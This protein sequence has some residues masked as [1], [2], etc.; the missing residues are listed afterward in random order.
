MSL[1]A[2]PWSQRPDDLPLTAEEV[3]AALFEAEGDVTAA[4]QRLKVGSLTLR[5]FIERSSRARAVIREMDSRLADKARSKL[6]QAL[7]DP[8]NRRVDWAIRYIL[9]SNNARHLGYSSTDNA[10]DPQRAAI[11]G[12]LVTLNLPPVEWQD[13]TKIGPRE[14]A[15]NVIELHP[16]SRPQAGEKDQDPSG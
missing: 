2:Y 13:G 5:K 1:P 8:D 10:G 16:S 9:N 15:K 4:S 3:C 12:P 11:N 6:G 14:L 7:D